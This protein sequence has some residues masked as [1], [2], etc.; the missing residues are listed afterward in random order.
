MR[1]FFQTNILVHTGVLFIGENLSNN[2]MSKLEYNETHCWCFLPF[3]QNTSLHYIFFLLLDYL[4]I[5]SF[6]SYY[7]IAVYTKKVKIWRKSHLF[8]Y[9]F[10]CGLLTWQLCAKKVW[11][12]PFA[13]FQKGRKLW[14]FFIQYDFFVLNKKRGFLQYNTCDMFL[15]SY[16][17]LK[18][19]LK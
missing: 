17:I 6:T 14:H 2:Q 5:H 11:R 19:H 1:Q 13:F 15:L 8:I 4:K 3:P 10:P 16:K 18:T 7:W 12:Q 9:T